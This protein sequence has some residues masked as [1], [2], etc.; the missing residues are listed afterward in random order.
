[1]PVKVGG[2]KF[3]KG[4]ERLAREG[5]VQPDAVCDTL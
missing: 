3:G 5:S 2:G 4:G 1:M